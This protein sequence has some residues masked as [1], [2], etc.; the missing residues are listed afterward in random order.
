MV[1]RSLIFTIALCCFVTSLKSRAF[2]Q[3]PEQIAGIQPEKMPS[4]EETV[5]YINRYI[6]YPASHPMPSFSHRDPCRG[7]REKRG[8]R[9]SLSSDK[10]KLIVTME[11]ECGRDIIEAFINDLRGFVYM[12]ESAKGESNHT[13]R[14][15]C[16]GSKGKYDYDNQIKCFN[17]SVPDGETLSFEEIALHVAPLDGRS[18]LEN[19]ERVENAFEHLIKSLQSESAKNEDNDPF[20]P[21][22]RP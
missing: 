22:K 5:S 6:T 15:P 16:K 2:A 11:Y 8:L 3:S 9:L 19:A 20:K 14:I 17:W 21:K 13:V 18:S 10:K 12:F 4:V 1:T 7:D